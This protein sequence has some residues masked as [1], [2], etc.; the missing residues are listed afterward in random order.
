MCVYVKKHVCVLSFTTN[1]IC[2]LWMIARRLNFPGRFGALAASTGKARITLVGVKKTTTMASV[3][4]S[5]HLSVHWTRDYQCFSFFLKSAP[6]G[7]G[8]AGQGGLWSN[9]DSPSLGDSSRW[10]HIGRYKDKIAARRMRA[11]LSRI[12]DVWCRPAE[13]TSLRAGSGDSC[14]IPSE[15]K[16]SVSFIIVVHRHYDTTDCKL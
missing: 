4:K 1:N 11:E 12:T 5:L 7:E 10:V 16:E 3:L 2:I 6:W 15:R 8:V 9:K 14:P 13:F